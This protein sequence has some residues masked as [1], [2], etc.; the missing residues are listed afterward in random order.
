MMR[1]WVCWSGKSFI[2]KGMH[3]LE[4][5]GRETMDLLATEKSIE[6]END[7]RETKQDGHEEQFFE[8]TNFD[9]YLWIYGGS[10]QLEVSCFL[11]VLLF[12]RLS[13]VI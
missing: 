10:E 5:V 2:A 13:S 1:F 12:N 6:I 4:L 7:G 9:R 3:V 11:S 8:E